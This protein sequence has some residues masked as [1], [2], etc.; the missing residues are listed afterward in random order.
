M[1]NPAFPLPSADEGIANYILPSEL[2]DRTLQ[3]N[4]ALNSGPE[5]RLQRVFTFE[6]W[7]KLKALGLTKLAWPK[8]RVL[9]VC[10]GT[11]FLSYH[12]LSKVPVDELIL[13]DTSEMELKE[14]ETLL[15][16]NFP[17]ARVSYCRL[18]L[19]K[20]GFP[21]SSFDLIIG[22]SFL[23]HLHDLPCAI[24]ELYRLLRPGGMFA[25]L[26]EPTP[27]AIAYESGSWD[28]I[29]QF[30]RQGAAYVELLRKGKASA[31]GSV[32]DVWL[33]EAERLVTLFRTEGFESIRVIPWNLLRPILVATN[34]LHLDD[35]KPALAPWEQ[36]LFVVSILSDAGL[37]RCLPAHA[38][39]ALSLAV[40]KPSC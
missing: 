30:C 5:R 11:G 20:T 13:L 25:T 18:D 34:K 10:C 8:L 32:I 31:D 28:L 16:K 37:R 12:L 23:H 26:H 2:A 40:C 36:I 9:D 22:N 39:G 27:V 38:F 1:L 17:R 24:R 33:F 21:P 19:L 29:C 7:T 15:V 6:I 35:L 3:G 4:A 14:S